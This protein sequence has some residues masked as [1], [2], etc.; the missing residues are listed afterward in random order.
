MISEHIYTSYLPKQPPYN[1]KY[2]KAL[3]Y[4]HKDN[5]DI[6]IIEWLDELVSFEDINRSKVKIPN[7]HFNPINRFLD[8]WDNA[9][10]KLSINSGIRN[11]GESKSRFRQFTVKMPYGDVIVESDF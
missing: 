8:D 3:A 10:E 4:E 11:H 6:F 1:I 5:S 9:I 7:E 2:P